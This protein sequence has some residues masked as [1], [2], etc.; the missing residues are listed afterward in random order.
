MVEMDGYVGRWVGRYRR[1]WVGGWGMVDKWIGKV[2]SAW[3]ARW[4]ACVY[5]L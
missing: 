1:S 2:G 4:V 5:S 3:V